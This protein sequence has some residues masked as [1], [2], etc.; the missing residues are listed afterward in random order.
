[1]AQQDMMGWVS[2]LQA[3]DEGRV[4][5]NGMMGA[6]LYKEPEENYLHLEIRNSDV[7]DEY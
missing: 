1:M 2:L 5:V 6:L 7:H 3:W 4:L